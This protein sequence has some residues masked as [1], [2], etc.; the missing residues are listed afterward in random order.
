MRH[1]ISK[2][3]IAFIL[4]AIIF[5]KFFACI[6]N[7]LSVSSSVYNYQS[8]A[9]KYLRWWMHFVILQMKT[10][11]VNSNTKQRQKYIMCSCHLPF[12]GIHQL[13]YILKRKRYCL[14]FFYRS[15]VK[16]NMNGF[17]PLVLWVSVLPLLN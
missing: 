16:H 8:R 11:T 13:M 17:R 1:V 14:L 12:Y 15:S 6:L 10:K 7:I 4:R 2:F 9:K 5:L 3:L